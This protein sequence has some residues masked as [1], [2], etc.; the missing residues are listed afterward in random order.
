MRSSRTEQSPT[1]PARAARDLAIRFFKYAILSPSAGAP[2]GRG[3]AA[4]RPKSASAGFPEVPPPSGFFRASSSARSALALYNLYLRRRALA[5]LQRGRVAATPR[6]RRGYF[7]GESRRRRGRDVDIPRRRDA[8]ARRYKNNLTK[9]PE[10]EA[11]EPGTFEGRPPAGSVS[12][13]PKKKGDKKG[14]GK[15]QKSVHFQHPAGFDRGLV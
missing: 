10:P 15:P 13:L 5:S 6:P 11:K 1:F 2:A 14:P 9:R 7:S 12:S 8:P 4:R 3:A